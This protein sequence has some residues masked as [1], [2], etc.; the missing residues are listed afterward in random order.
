[1]RFDILQ[2]ASTDHGPPFTVG[3]VTTKLEVGVEH[4]KVLKCKFLSDATSV[5][6]Y[7][8]IRLEKNRACVRACAR[9]R[10]LTLDGFDIG[11]IKS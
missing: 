7:D 9:A 2:E 5:A 1:M 6:D 10:D 11:W 4:Q 8:S 3:A